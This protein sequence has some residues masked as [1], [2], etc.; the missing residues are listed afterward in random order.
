MLPLAIDTG[1]LRLRKPLAAD[2]R[3][4]FAAYAQDPDVTR[5]LVWRPHASIDDTR[6][7]IADCLERWGRSAYPYVITSRSDG[8]V[9]GMIEARLSESLASVGYVLAKRWWGHGFTTEAVRAVVA[10]AFAQPLIQRVEAACDVD[11]A[12]SSRVLEKAGFRLERRAPAYLVHPNISGEP[13][14]C[15]VYAIYRERRGHTNQ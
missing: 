2:A 11:N 9:L 13:R 14:D 4:I 8:S 1:R 7:F 5:Y 6:A 10:A 12:A 15:F 3:A